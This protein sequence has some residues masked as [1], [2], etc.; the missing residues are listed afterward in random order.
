MKLGKYKHF[1]GN[2][3]EALY[4]AKHSETLEEMVVYRALYGEFGIWVRPMSMWNETVVHEGREVQR[5]TYI[6]KEDEN[7]Y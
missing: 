6:G 3:Y 4:V 7:E 5:F 1:K 2:E